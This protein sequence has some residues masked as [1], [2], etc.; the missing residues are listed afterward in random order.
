MYCSN[1]DD[2]PDCSSDAETLRK[3]INGT[4]GPMERILGQF[5]VDIYFVRQVILI[6][7]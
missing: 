6:V 7:N 5:D 2:L 4:I 3:G 1:V